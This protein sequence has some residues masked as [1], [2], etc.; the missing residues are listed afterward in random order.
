M[1][2]KTN[3]EKVKEINKKRR[4]PVKRKTNE[5][6]INLLKEANLHPAYL[7]SIKGDKGTIIGLTHAEITQGNKNIALKDNPNPKDKKKAYL[8]P[9]IKD[10]PMAK[11][12]QK[13]YKGWKMS[14]ENKKIAKKLKKE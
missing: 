5:I 4:K 12:S 7:I 6:R 3:I 11:L 2:N 8:K 14:R 1:K 10:V 13:P 9:P